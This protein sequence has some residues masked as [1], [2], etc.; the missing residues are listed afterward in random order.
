[1]SSPHTTRNPR[2]GR[3]L[4]VPLPLV[5]LL[6]LPTIMPLQPPLVPPPAA[7]AAASHYH[8]AVAADT[9][10]KP[11]RLDAAA[12]LTGLG[13]LQECRELRRVCWKSGTYVV[14]PNAD[15]TVPRTPRFPNW[16]RA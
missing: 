11:P 10:S 15:G 5:L 2:R 1:M 4:T 9:C 7:A 3:G 13:A 14:H 6:H 8:P 12:L 16:P